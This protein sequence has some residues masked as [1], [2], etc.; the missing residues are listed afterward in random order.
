MTGLHSLLMSTGAVVAGVLTVR[1]VRALRRRGGVL[2]GLGLVSAGITALCAG[3]S[4]LVTLPAA[5]VAGTGGSIMLNASN[6]GLSDHHGE[7]AATALSEGNALAAGVGLLA[8]LAVGLGVGLGLTWRP[9]ALVVL[10]LGLLT[11][12]ALRRVPRGTPALDAVPP[13]RPDG[14]HAPLG[15]RFGLLTAA[16]VLGVGIEFA[17]TAWAADL[18]RLR[19]G[20]SP[21]AA[22]AGVTAIVAGL[23]V[24]RLVAARLALR[25]PPRTVLLGSLGLALAGWALL[26]TT[27]SPA[28][29]LAGLFA[30]GLG[31]A[32]QYPIGVSLVYAAVGAQGDRATGIVSLGVGAL[33]AVTPF[34]LG[35][36]ADA[37]STHTAFLVVPV[38]V[39]AA[40]G[41]L[42]A[43]GPGPRPAR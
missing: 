5:L 28:V 39:V 41:F 37:T 33:A 21:G 14:G 38:L 6:P 17:N 8:P 23:T 3:G 13:P 34:V 29:A 42:L 27:T 19:T 35:A 9:A 25:V 1:L 11:V 18:L 40:A 16:L 20:M 43:A 36:L 31:I 4:P 15:R 7:T 26:W 22:S 32:G 2:L 10:P 24:G 12:L 30:T